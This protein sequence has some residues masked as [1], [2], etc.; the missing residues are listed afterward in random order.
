MPPLSPWQRIPRPAPTAPSMD[1]RGGTVVKRTASTDQGFR[2]DNVRPGTYTVRLTLPEQASPAADS[3]STFVASGL[4]MTQSGVTVEAGEDVDG[5]TTGLVS[6]TSVAGR[7]YLDENGARTPL[8]G[9]TVSL[10]RGGELSPLMTVLTDDSGRY[11]FDG[12]WPDDYYLEA[13]LPSGTIFVRP[14]DPNYES[15][16]SAVTASGEGSGTS[17]LFYL[18]MA[19]HR[20]DMDVIYIKP[21]RV[22]DLAWLDENGNGLIDE[23][24]PGIPG[25]TVRLVQD[26]EAVYETV[27]DAYGYYLFTD[28]YPGAYTLVAQ[29]YPELTPTKQVE[30]LRIISSCLVGGDGTEAHSDSFEVESGS[31]NVNFDLGYLLREGESLPSAITAPP[32]RDWTISNGAAQ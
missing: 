1:E 23:G 9:V 22:G 27:T 2:F 28:V 4:K 21:A 18:H 29:A 5:L 13:G 14:G 6:T 11:R 20:L 19:Q 17:D 30:T 32:T 12:L 24:E 26:G 7:L 31:L 3:A 10:Y 8:A 15:G 25:I 16:A